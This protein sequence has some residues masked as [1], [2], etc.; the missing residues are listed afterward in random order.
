MGSRIELTRT[1]SNVLCDWRSSFYAKKSDGIKSIP[2]FITPGGEQELP[3]VLFHHR[4]RNE[5]ILEPGTSANPEKSPQ[6][7][8]KSLK[9]CSTLSSIITQI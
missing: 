8:S 5:N 4:N 7:C 3:L 9:P 6:H 2:Y 1:D